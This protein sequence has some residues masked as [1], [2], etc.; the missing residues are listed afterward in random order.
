MNREILEINDFM[1]LLE[2]SSS[3]QTV[4]ETCDFEEPV[5]GMAFYGSG[6]VSLK[7]EFGDQ[8][9]IF[10]T[11]KGYA[12]S[13]FAN[14]HAK[15]I[16]TISQERPLQCIVILSSI[17][18]LK[19]LPAEESEAYSSYMNELIQ[20]KE[21][22]KRGPSLFMNNDMLTAVDKIFTNT[23]TNKMRSMFLKSQV[24]EL[25]SH[26]FAIVADENSSEEIV[27]TDERKKLYEAKEIL[28]N[29]IES[30]PSLSELS[31]Q[32]GLNS[33]KLKKSFKELFGVPVFK[34]LQNERLNKANSLL[35][36]E[37]VT[38][39]EA[40]WMVGYDSVS[41][42]SNAFTKKFGFRPSDVKR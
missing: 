4:I 41:S 38:I 20:T 25:I 33:Y 19:K 18:N 42:F 30:P 9:E 28:A 26:F 2:Q 6:D 21:H 14:Q 34:H 12:M 7:I 16:H 37:Q 11:T 24:T 1:V 32:I 5:I 13:F 23:Y 10:D 29:N 8:H 36:D 27:N 40:A 31:K 22:F 15:F 17:K 35:R 3:E 39:Q